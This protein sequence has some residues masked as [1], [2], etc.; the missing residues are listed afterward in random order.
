[1][2]KFFL[3]LAGMLCGFPLV[4]TAI[5]RVGNGGVKSDLNGYEVTV[6]GDFSNIQFF[7]GE[8]AR[9]Y[10]ISSFFAPLKTIE[11]R[12]FATEFPAQVGKS[13]ND[14]ESTL[15]LSDWKS[16]GVL[17]NCARIYAQETATTLAYMAIWSSTKGYV[18][19]AEKNAQAKS[20]LTR[21]LE[22]TVLAP[23]VCE[24]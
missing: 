10:N 7:A 19:L 15:L 20:Y 16:E 24:W 6:P 4:S 22:S 14:I 2:K 17:Q 18:L 23:G 13:R 21:I 3:I 12:N 5:S 8:N 11:L 1:M 9:F